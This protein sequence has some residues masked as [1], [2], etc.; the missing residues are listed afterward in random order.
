MAKVKKNPKKK[1]EAELIRDWQ[2]RHNKSVKAERDELKQNPSYKDWKKWYSTTTA[3]ALKAEESRLKDNCAFQ[4]ALKVL[5][6]AHPL[7]MRNSSGWVCREFRNK[8]DEAAWTIFANKWRLQLKPLMWVNIQKID[9]IPNSMYIDASG[10][11][12][13]TSH[14][15]VSSRHAR[16]HRP[17]ERLYDRL[18]YGNPVKRRG[19]IS[20][21]KKKERLFF[22]Q[23]LWDCFWRA[24]DKEGGFPNIIMKKML[25]PGGIT[26]NPACSIKA[27]S[28]LKKLVYSPRP[29]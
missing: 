5:Q 26:D 29:K 8:E 11:P 1:T 28:S 6:D 19:S 3:K 15:F 10:K 14:G 22:K 27:I 24:R 18:A 17:I 4:A 20:L 9:P 2:C 23:V 12:I 25:D 13:R 16:D 7:I 21:K